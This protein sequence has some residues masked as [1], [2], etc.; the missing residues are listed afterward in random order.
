MIKVSGLP[1]QVTKSE[2]DE[3]FSPYGAILVTEDSPSIEMQ[4]SE[5]IAYVSLD[6]NESKAIRELSNT[7]WLGTNL[8]YLDPIRGERRLGQIG[9]GGQG[10]RESG[11]QRSDSQGN[12]QSKG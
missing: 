9:S 10:N 1:I 6:Q 12:N 8:L 7:V 5:S 3:L 2:L 11:T 4:G